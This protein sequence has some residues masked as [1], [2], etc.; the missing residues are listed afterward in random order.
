MKG[1]ADAQAECAVSMGLL[2][3]DSLDEEGG[4]AAFE[5]S[6]GRILAIPTSTTI[7]QLRVSRQDKWMY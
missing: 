7:I 4:T 5:V 3:F 2:L 1:R 6:K